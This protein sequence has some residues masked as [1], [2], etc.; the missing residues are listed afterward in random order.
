MHLGLSDK[1]HFSEERTLKM[2]PMVMKEPVL[3]GEGRMF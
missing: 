2:S 3:R 1:D